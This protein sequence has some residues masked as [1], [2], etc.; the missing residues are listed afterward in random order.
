MSP[1]SHKWHAEP[2]ARTK[3][4]EHVVVEVA[5]GSSDCRAI[6]TELSAVTGETGAK[7]PLSATRRARSGCMKRWRRG[8][9]EPLKCGAGGAHPKIESEPKRSPTLSKGLPNG[10]KR[11]AGTRALMGRARPAAGDRAVLDA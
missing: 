9:R 5:E 3:R 6:P 11:W 4:D 10:L 2:G 8:W 1:R 7:A